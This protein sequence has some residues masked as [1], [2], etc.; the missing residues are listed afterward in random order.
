MSSILFVFA[1]TPHTSINAQEGL[2]ALLMGSAFT[3]CR[4]LF[5]GAGLTQLISHQDAAQIGRKNYAQGFSAL[6]DY[7]VTQ[8]ACRQSD[9]EALNLGRDQLSLEIQV[10]DDA[11]CRHWI[12]EADKVLNFR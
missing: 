9:L 11:A 12:D 1:G 2:D 7:G 10:L 4:L 8:V 6:T 3:E 5:L